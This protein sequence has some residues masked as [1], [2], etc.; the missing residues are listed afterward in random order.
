[1]DEHYPPEYEEDAF[2]CPHCSTYS[3]HRWSGLKSYVSNEWFI[4]WK[5][6]I[7]TRC[8]GHTIWTRDEEMV[9]PRTTIAPEPSEDMPEDVK[10]DYQEAQHVVEDSPRAAAALLRLAMEK[11]ARELTNEGD[12]K[13]YQMIGDLKK[14][15]RIDDRIQQALDSVRVT[16]NNW[17]HPGELNVTDD[18]ETAYRL[19]ELVNAVVEITIARDNLIEEQYSKVPENKMEGI[20]QRDGS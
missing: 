12:K 8:E 7:C 2:H 18:H 16:G 11:L 1:M 20:R 3:H 17:V 19:F 5:A 15:G 10:E 13:L 4:Q 14:E 9:Y 6:S